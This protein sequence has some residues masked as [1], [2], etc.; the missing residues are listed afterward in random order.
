MANPQA[1]VA[2]A[3]KTTDRVVLTFDM[4]VEQALHLVASGKV[5]MEAYLEWDAIRVKAIR[6]QASS[7]GGGQVRCKVSEKGALSL[8]G[9]QRL[10]VTLYAE[11]WERLLSDANRTMVPEFIKSNPS[12]SR[13]QR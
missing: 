4:T 12:L 8:Y 1:P 2:N 3:P 9:L 10:P 5:T 6:A 7:A 13:K 11:Q